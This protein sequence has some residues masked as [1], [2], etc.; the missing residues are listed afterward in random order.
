MALEAGKGNKPTMGGMLIVLATAIGTLLFARLDYPLVLAA[1]WTMVA[2]GVLGGMDDRIKLL[3]LPDPKHPGRTRKGMDAWPKVFGQVLIGAVAITWLWLTMKDTPGWAEFRAF[4]FAL[5]AHFTV[6]GVQLPSVLAGVMFVAVGI[7]VL[8]GTSNAVNLTDGLDGLAAGCGTIVILV[9]MVMAYIVGRTDFAAHMG[10]PFIREGGELAV[11]LAALAGATA[12][13]LWWNCQ[14]AQVFMGN[15]GAMALGGALAIS[16]IGMRQE[17]VLLIAGGAF[18]W[19]A[20]SVILQVW[21]F[22][23]RGK[24]IFKCAPYHHD[25]QFRGWSESRVVMSFWIGTA[26]SGV[27]ALGLHR[28]L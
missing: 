19:E 20:V 8:V 25:L 5:P 10:Q 17:V 15:T 23:T 12:G 1:L 3:G 6:L 28:V 27:V 24:R 21:S 2:M 16:A 9:L 4:G 14:P 11:F 26:V 13:F 18:A 22:K 7:F